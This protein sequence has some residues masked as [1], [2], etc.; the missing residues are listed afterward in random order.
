MSQIGDLSRTE[1]GKSLLRIGPGAGVH[2]CCLH[3][4]EFEFGEGCAGD[5]FFLIRFRST[6]IRIIEWAGRDALCF[7]D[8]RIAGSLRADADGASGRGGRFGGSDQAINRDD[9]AIKA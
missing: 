9:I 3:R 8:F 4:I 5:L 6:P 2:L 1:P 7:R